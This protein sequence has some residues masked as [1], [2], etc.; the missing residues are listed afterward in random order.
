MAREWRSSE[1]SGAVGYD[2]GRRHEHELVL[3]P[4]PP[5][6]EAGGDA[7]RQVV[8]AS[9]GAGGVTTALVASRDV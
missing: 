4:L 3:Q 9:Y 6:Q 2:D 5:G 1:E 7:G 8:L